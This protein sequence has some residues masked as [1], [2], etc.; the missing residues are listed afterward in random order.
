VRYALRDPTDWRKVRSPFAQRNRATEEQKRKGWEMAVRI[1]LIL[2]T[3]LNESHKRQV[4]EVIDTLQEGRRAC[5]GIRLASIRAE[6]TP[7]RVD[8]TWVPGV[9]VGCA[10]PARVQSRQNIRH[11]V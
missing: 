3:L 1:E 8:G 11:S 10:G 6:S 9:K 5:I 4:Q 7:G 2:Y